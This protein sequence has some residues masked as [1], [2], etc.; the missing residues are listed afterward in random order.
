MFSL[1]RGHIE[2]IVVVSPSS[3]DMGNKSKPVLPHEKPSPPK[4]QLDLCDPCGLGCWVSDPTFR[5]L[6]SAAEPRSGSESITAAANKPDRP[7]IAESTDVIDLAARLSHKETGESLQ[8]IPEGAPWTAWEESAFMRAQCV[9]GTD[10]CAI[11]RLLEGRSCCEV[12]SKLAALRAG[13]STIGQ[14]TNREFQV[15]KSRSSKKVLEGVC[16]SAGYVSRLITIT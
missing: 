16:L 8:K 9:Y 14:A 2:Q 4:V 7:M 12:A 5:H 6:L 1:R 15:Q 10:C 3:G 13:G 11:A